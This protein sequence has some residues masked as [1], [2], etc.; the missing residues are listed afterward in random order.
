[1]KNYLL[2]IA[3]FTILVS[4]NSCKKE[5]TPTQFCKATKWSI[6]SQS[7]A[8]IYDA[9]GFIKKATGLDGS[10]SDYTQSGNLLTRQSYSSAG[11]PTGTITL[12]VNDAG[13]VIFDASNPDTMLYKYNSE[14]QLSEFVRRQDTVKSRVVIS[15]NGGD[16]QNI[17][18]YK[19]DS[20]IKSTKVYEY[21]TDRENN[22]NLN[23][24]YD[25]IDSRFGKPAKHFVKRI[26]T[27]TSS[28]T[29]SYTYLTYTF[30]DRGSA[31]KVQI[32]N[33][34]DNYVTDITFDYSCE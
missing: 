16:I 9:S 33:Q 6:G 13:Y 11:L 17:I 23:I 20:T 8:Y 3:V 14:G 25:L 19:A 12:T 27:G 18:E 31:T 29:L 7:I 15:Y 26:T 22:T 30:D 10:Y 21:Y 4:Q 34:P 5:T 1:M 32:V 2:V 24:S 28:N